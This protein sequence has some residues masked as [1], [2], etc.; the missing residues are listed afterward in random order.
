MYDSSN[1]TRV[2]SP[3]E[4][5]VQHNAIDKKYN[6]DA[7]NNS[8][9]CFCAAPCHNVRPKDIGRYHIIGYPHVCQI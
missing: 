5:D 7:E 3:D 2:A 6:T 1:L 9:V 4:I 8:K